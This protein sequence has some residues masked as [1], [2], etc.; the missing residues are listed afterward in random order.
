MSDRR[1]ENVRSI[2]PIQVLIASRDARYLKLVSFLLERRGFVVELTR[3]LS[4][5]IDT[6]DRSQPNVVVLDASGW[7]DPAAR[8]IAALEVLYPNLRVI[9]VSEDSAASSLGGISILDK[10]G[11]IDELQHEVELAYLLAPPLQHG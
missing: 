11:P 8:R 1:L 3:K 6:V 4:E 7:L 2:Q 10:W 9:A 5:L